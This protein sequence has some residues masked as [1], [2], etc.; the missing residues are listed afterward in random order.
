MNRFDQLRSNLDKGSMVGIEI[1]PFYSPVAPKRHG[2]KTTVIDFQDGAAL[3]ASAGGHP[4]DAIRKRV[5]Q[6]EDVDIVWRGEPLDN[7]ALARNPEGYDYFIASHVIEHTPDILSFLQQVSRLLRKGGIVSL[8]VP[9]MRKCFDLFKP[10]SSLREVLVAYREKR[11]RHTPETLLEARAMSVS[12]DGS[13]SW[14]AGSKTP[15]KF[16]GNFDHAWLSYQNDVVNTAGDYI[17]AHAWFFTPSS[18]ELLIHELNYMGMLDLVIRSL[19]ENPGS[20]FIV[21]LQARSRASKMTLAEFDLI[22]ID[23]STRQA[24]EFAAEV[25]GGPAKAPARTVYVEIPVEPPVQSTAAL[26]RLLFT[27]IWRK[28]ISMVGMAN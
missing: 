25:V 14:L 18:F 6:I 17:D 27:R 22:R 26:A 21:Q 7:L 24:A 23:L 16:T 9:D 10:P 8:A 4:V 28:A 2:W 13:G 19:E 3:R 1:G 15:L 11:I 5:G 12:R 20:E